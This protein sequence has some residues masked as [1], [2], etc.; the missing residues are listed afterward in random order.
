MS[1]YHTPAEITESK[2]Y[3]EPS[4]EEVGDKQGKQE[5]DSRPGAS[6]LVDVSRPEQNSGVTSPDRNNIE[7]VPAEYFRGVQAAQLIQSGL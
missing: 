3:K 7:Y 1:R 4:K 2:D 6:R 5:M